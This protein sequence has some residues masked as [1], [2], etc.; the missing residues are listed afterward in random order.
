MNEQ[1]PHDLTEGWPEDPQN[2]EL[3][4]FATELQAA[5]PALPAEALARVEQTIQGELQR[6]RAPWRRWMHLAVAASVLLALG[7]GGFLWL[8]PAPEEH[9]AP[10]VEDRYTVKL[11]P[12][13]V[14]LP[15]QPPLVRLE[16]HQSLFA[17]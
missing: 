2:E 3:A 7:V 4:R 14:P 12:P 1:E 13:V 5:L 8:R 16:E 6:R 9:S 17:D 10:R 15:P 11:A